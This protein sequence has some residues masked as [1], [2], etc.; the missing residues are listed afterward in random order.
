MPEQ[1]DLRADCEIFVEKLGNDEDE[2]VALVS[3]LESVLTLYCKSRELIYR[4]DNGWLEILQPLIALK[5]PKSELYNCF[6]AIMSKYIPRDCAKDGK[7]FHLFRL[8]LLYHDPELCSF[9][10]TKK[11]TPD[12]YSQSWL[13]SLFAAHCDLEVTLVMW[14][15][16][17]QAADPFLVFFLALVIIINAKEQLLAMAEESRSQISENLATFPC[18]LEAEDIED[19]CSLAQYYASKTPQSFRRDYQNLYK[20]SDE[21]VEDGMSAYV[22][23]AL[24]LPVSVHELLQTTSQPDD[25]VR[26]F[27]V[28]CRPAEQYNS[29]HLPT[30][31]HLDANLM[32]QEP[33]EFA[34]AVNA[35]FASQ[36][37]A[38]AAGSV[39]GGEHLCFMGS[40]REEEDQYVHMVVAN[41]LQRKKQYVS[42]ARG[43]YAVLH[44]VLGDDVSYTLADHSPRHCIVCNPDAE[45]NG[46][47]FSDAAE[48]FQHLLQEG[49]TLFGKLSSALKGKS[50]KVKE[51]LTN[52]IVNP[53]G[54]APP[55]DR[56]VTPSDKLGKRYRGMGPV[57]TIDDD[58]NDAEVGGMPSSDDENKECVS[59]ETWVRKP[60]VLGTFKCHEIKENGYMHSCH[61]LVTKT[62]MFILRDIPD[63]KDM[64][65]IIARRV[66][67]SIVKITS[68]KRH[69]ELITFRYGTSEDD[70]LEF[71]DCD[72][73]LIPNSGDATK[74]VKQQILQHIEPVTAATPT[75]AEPENK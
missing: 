42:L 52:Y 12:V 66:L 26:Y 39:A 2:R 25:G 62:H 28:D 57:F 71:T 34:S 46:R 51:Q 45:L 38:I 1:K 14:D 17:L 18:A 27:I 69:P 29:G 75:P 61:L 13:R 3:D 72:R 30:A 44:S 54:T 41:F 67:S 21:Y 64:A 56:H 53:T 60:E 32:L 15:V 73:F 16:Y 35:L 8:L 37:Q 31:F 43:G 63:R 19:F 6:C 22:K 33:G 70:G 74:L 58:D 48:E 20:V 5:M 47:D 49:S 55:R 50:E 4:T 10:D 59:V 9:L 36:K 40:G 7:P 23:Q 68:K 65:Y 24:C 11:I